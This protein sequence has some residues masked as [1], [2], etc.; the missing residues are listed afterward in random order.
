MTAPVL[1]TE[2]LVKIY[3]R[4]DTRF[5]ALKGINLEIG[6]GES[7]AVVGKSGSGKSTL[8]HLLALLDAPTHGVVALEG[9]PTGDLGAKELNELRNSAFGFVFQQFFL[10]PNQTVLENTVLPLKIAGVGRAERT[11]RGMAVLERLELADK[12]KNKATDLSGGQKQRVCIARALVNNPT[13][14]FA[15]E[16]TGNLD[17][18]TS[19]AVED[20]LFGLQR[21]EGITLVVVTHDDDLAAKCDRRVELQD[22]VVIADER[23]G[24]ERDGARA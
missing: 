23:V 18:A 11:R 3:G 17:S 16:P 7:V 8:M 13:V 12:A 9:R 24:T 4:G 14:L 22:G 2:N 15:D 1:E 20:I 6:K 19:A 5:D 21:D 10:N